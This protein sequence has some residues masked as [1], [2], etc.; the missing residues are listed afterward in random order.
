MEGEMHVREV[1]MLE[2]ARR[3]KLLEQKQPL[4]HNE[5]DRFDRTLWLDDSIIKVSCY[6]L[7][8]LAG[9]SATMVDCYEC[10]RLDH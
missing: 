4:E 2:I 10:E 8:C 9:Y 7:S 3:W 6:Y 1:E 5:E